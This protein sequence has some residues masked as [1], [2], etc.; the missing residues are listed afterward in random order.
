MTGRYKMNVVELEEIISE[1]EG[2]HLTDLLDS[3][4]AVKLPTE[5]Y[6]IV[7]LKTK[8]LNYIDYELAE[9]LYKTQNDQYHYAKAQFWAENQYGDA[10]ED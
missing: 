7:N 5:S 10:G 1:N 9:K 8:M 6:A 3:F 2:T 4:M